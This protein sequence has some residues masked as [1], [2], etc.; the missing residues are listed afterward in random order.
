MYN[1]SS[2]RY[3]CIP[4]Q[5]GGIRAYLGR[6]ERITCVDIKAAIDETRNLILPVPAEVGES[7]I[8]VNEGRA[9]ESNA[10]KVEDNVDGIDGARLVADFHAAQYDF[11]EEANKALLGLRELCN[12]LR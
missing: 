11:I 2:M 3:T 8:I 7:G 12:K 4:R 5:V 1:Y 10:V 6:W 9:C